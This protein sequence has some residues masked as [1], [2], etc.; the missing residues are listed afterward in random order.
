MNATNR[1][2]TRLLSTGMLAVVVTVG[3]FSAGCSHQS[4]TAT[5]FPQGSPQNPAEAKAAAQKYAD[6]MQKKMGQQ[7]QGQQQQGQ[8]Q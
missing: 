8:G 1:L 7:G 3:I 6:Y 4:N 5:G 2:T